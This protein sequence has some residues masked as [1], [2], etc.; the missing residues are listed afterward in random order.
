[1]RNLKKSGFTAISYHKHSK[2][3]FYRDFPRHLEASE[4]QFEKAAG[5][6]SRAHGFERF[7]VNVGFEIK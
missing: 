6:H 1:M 3:E 7:E 2:T 4:D 5:A